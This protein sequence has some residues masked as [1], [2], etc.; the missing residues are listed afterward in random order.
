MNILLAITR[1]IMLL[2]MTPIWLLWWMFFDSKNFYGFITRQ[3]PTEMDGLGWV[4]IVIGIVVIITIGWI[5]WRKFNSS[6]T[7]I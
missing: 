3:H 1:L 7:P 2:I 5:C 4:I 6:H